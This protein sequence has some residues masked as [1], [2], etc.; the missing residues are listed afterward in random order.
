MANENR[1][2]IAAVYKTNYNLAAMLKTSIFIQ[3]FVIFCI[4][5]HFMFKE[6]NYLHCFLTSVMY[7]FLEFVQIKKE[8]SNNMNMLISYMFFLYFFFNRF[9]ED[10]MMICLENPCIGVVGTICSTSLIFIKLE[11]SKLAQFWF[12]SFTILLFLVLPIIRILLE[13]N[14]NLIIYKW[15]ECMSCNCC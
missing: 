4:S 11:S 3:N 5:F 12:I 13:K 8:K 1:E 7:I 6:S 2:T 15:D 10:W 9:N 14:R